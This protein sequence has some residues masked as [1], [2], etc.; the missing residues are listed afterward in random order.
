MVFHIFGFSLTLLP[1][2]QPPK[3]FIF[4]MVIFKKNFHPYEDDYGQIQV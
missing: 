3:N 1:P 2:P 4:R